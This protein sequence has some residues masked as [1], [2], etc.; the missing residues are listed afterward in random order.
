M[1]TIILEIMYILIGLIILYNGFSSLKNQENE[2]RVITS[3]FWFVLSVTFILPNLQIFWKGEKPFIPNIMIGYLVVLMAVLSLLKKVSINNYKTVSKEFLVEKAEKIGNLIFIPALAIGIL[4]FIVYMIQDKLSLGLGS[5]AS[6]GIAILIS[7]I[8]GL[9][10]TKD[11]ASNSIKE[12][13]RLLDLV[14][15]M[16]ILPQILAALGSI[17]TTAGVGVYISNTL[18]G[19]IPENN[20]LIGV[21]VYCVSMALFTIIMGNGFAAFSVITAGIG[22]PFVIANG[23]NPAIV[24]AFGLTAGYCGTLL[25]PMA[26]NFNIV[27]ASILEI[28]DKKWGI[29]KYQA[30]ISIILLVIHIVLMY[31]LAF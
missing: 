1:S 25:T 29:I 31:T 28:K 30:P 22:V 17:F 10:I 21:I 18:G 5:I 27:P 14:G 6:L 26:A 2:N 8:L 11:S 19:V 4:S 7:T 13:R 20:I 23:G 24:G 12:G 16:S 9:I 3:L 15:P